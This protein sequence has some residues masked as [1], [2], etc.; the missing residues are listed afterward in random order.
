MRSAISLSFYFFYL[1]A[2]EFPLFFILCIRNYTNKN[3][4]FFLIMLLVS[5]ILNFLIFYYIKNSIEDTKKKGAIKTSIIHNFSENKINQSLSD[6]FAF[7]LL[8]FFTF[9]FSNEV[10]LIQ[11]GIEMFTLLLLLTIFLLRTKNY[12]SNIFIYMLF[13][14]YECTIPGK[15]ILILTPNYKADLQT[16]GNS[17]LCLLV[18]NVYIDK[19]EKLIKK[20]D[21]LIHLFIFVAVLCIVLILIKI[22]LIS[23]IW[24]FF[25]TLK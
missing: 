18:E 17:N 25:L 5:V 14:L 13:N 6:F 23:V 1:I 15:Q 20:L 21:T 4:I 8:P 19:D 22:N 16:E 3:I 12:T 9:N 7:F 2:A 24:D 10:N 11:L